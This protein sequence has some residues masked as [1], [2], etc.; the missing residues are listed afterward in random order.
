M[1]IILSEKHGVNPS[2][3]I[4]FFCKEAKGIVLFGKLKNDIEAPR[5]VL[6]NY[7]PCE[8]CKEKFKEGV[9]VVAET[10]AQQ[11]KNQPPITTHNNEELYPTGAYAVVKPTAF[12]NKYKVGTIITMDKNLFQ[13]LFKN[14]RGVDE[15]AN[16]T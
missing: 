15:N 4:C 7:E 10:T 11:C 1:S 13:E 9:I 8:K 14:I 2:M 16:R 12:D 5:E 6:I 3:E